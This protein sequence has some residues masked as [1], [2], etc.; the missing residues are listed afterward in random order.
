MTGGAGDKVKGM[1][2]Q[3]VGR[4]KEGVG[5]AT[6]NERLE[7]EGRVD[8]V[9]GQGN[10]LKGDVKSKLDELGDKVDDKIDDMR[11]RP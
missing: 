5:V 8:Q 6:D 11:G 7:G 2:Q 3:A 10:E 4:A 9:R 1:A